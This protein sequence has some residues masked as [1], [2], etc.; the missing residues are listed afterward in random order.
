MPRSRK[1]ELEEILDDITEDSNSSIDDSI[2][3]GNK[4]DWSEAYVFLKLL[5]D[6][7]MYVADGS[8]NRLAGLYYP[9]IKVIRSEAG[10]GLEYLTK[11]SIIEV[12]D[13]KSG[14]SL[15][16]I[17]KAELKSWAETLLGKIRTGKGR[18]F[19]IPD[20]SKNLASL[21][22][23]TLK[24]QS[25]DKSDITIVV[26]DY[27]TGQ[28]PILGFSIKSMLGNPSTLLNPGN[29]TNV[30]Y[31][32]V[33]REVTL[34]DVDR[35]NE[36][37]TR[38]KIK[39]RVGKLS[40]LGLCLRYLDMQSKMFK[41]NLTVIDSRMP[42]I[43]ARTLL[44]FHQEGLSCISDIINRLSELNPLEFDFSQSHSFYDY[45]IK[46]LLT[47]VALGMTPSKVW[48]GQYDATGGYIVVT[49]DGD[50]VCI[51]FYNRNEF[52]QYLVNNSR[53]DSGGT[54]R[55]DYGYAYW[56]GARPIMKLNLQVRF[57][58]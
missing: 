28:D 12:I 31:E 48:S 20:M 32:I 22:V 29:T 5:S 46:N 3:T 57:N 37:N 6:G 13:A 35:I 14:A 42:E 36:V 8:L 26:H 2:V 17:P 52:Q 33:G 30:M 16:T 9:I 49:K 47:D 44:L 7:I 39:D 45:K 1:K 27:Q 50:V 18:A 15:L 4:G 41:L 51:P 34:S 40:D 43:V 25:L 58:G 56:E 55:Y 23:K 21:G 19:A 24:A 11:G 38:K 54:D 53:L 10:R